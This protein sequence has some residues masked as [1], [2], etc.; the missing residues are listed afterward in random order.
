MAIQGTV[1]SVTKPKQTTTSL[2]NGGVD[3][4]TADAALKK[5]IVQNQT[6]IANDSG[7]RNDE[8]QRALQVIAQR[9]SAGLDTSAQQKYL[10]Q[11]LGYQYPN[12]TAN[13]S[14]TGTATPS[15]TTSASTAAKTNVQQGSGL[16][17]LMR[18]IATRE[19]TPFSYDPNSDPAYQAALKRAQANIEQGNAAV[20]AELNRRGL[21][22]STITSDRMGEIS[23]NELGRVET[24]VLPSLM[25]QAY[26]QYLNNLNQQQQQYSNIANLAQLYLNEDQRAIDNTNTRAGLTGYLPGGEQAQSLVNQLLSLKQQAET[27][28]ITAAERTRL[29]NQADG[30]RAMLAQMGVDA[31]QYGANVNYATASQVAPTIRTLAGQQLDMQRQGQAFDQQFAQEQ[32]AY[33][34]ARDAIS[35]QRW[36]AEFDENVR[37]FGLNYAL[38]RLQESNQQAYRQAQLALAQDDNSRAWAQLDYQMSQPASTSGGLTANQ[39]LQSIQSLYRDPDTGKI[40][41]DSGQREQMFLNVVDSGLSDQETNQILSAL[42]FSKSEINSLTKKYGGSSGN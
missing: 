40:T 8:I 5:Q 7:Y 16:M 2:G 3:Y 17:D 9:Q 23:A 10:T 28:G 4:N 39:V 13:T 42:G 25:Q 15:N 36:K 31:S 1:V 33:Q 12:A 6:R 18:Q 14:F 26:N 19:V 34:K 35:D 11:N 22:N 41:T 38:N 24:D 37:Q 20:Q 30:I 21:L 29:S 27:P 32:F